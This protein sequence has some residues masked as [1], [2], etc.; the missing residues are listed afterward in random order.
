M[1]DPPFLA[2]FG[3]VGSPFLGQGWFAPGAVTEFVGVPGVLGAILGFA[4]AHWD[5]MNRT[6]DDRFFFIFLDILWAGFSFRMVLLSV[7]V[8][9]TRFF[10][11]RFIRMRF[12]DTRWRA[13]A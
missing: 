7:R 1:Q 3:R 8:F 4:K 2:V 11:M 9:R 5:L 13:L 12:F 6:D 10:R